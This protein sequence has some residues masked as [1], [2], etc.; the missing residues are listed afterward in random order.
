MDR[1]TGRRLAAAQEAGEIT[2][3]GDAYRMASFIVAGF[4]GAVARAKLTG[5]GTPGVPRNRH[6][7]LA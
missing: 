2:N 4:E 1:E 6:P 7:I 5:H 3:K